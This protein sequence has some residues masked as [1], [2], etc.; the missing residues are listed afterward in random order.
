MF[1]ESVEVTHIDDDDEGQDERDVIEH[2]HEVNDEYENCLIYLERLH[3]TPD[4]EGV[5]LV[6]EVGGNDDVDE[7]E[8]DEPTEDDIKVALQHIIDDEGVEAV[9]VDLVEHDAS[10]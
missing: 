6:H 5:E 8:H 2:H 7:V 4:D 9:E 1:D 3:I 10:E